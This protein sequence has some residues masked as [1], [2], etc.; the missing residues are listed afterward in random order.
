MLSKEVKPLELES[1]GMFSEDDMNK[2]QEAIESAPILTAEELKK[3]RFHWF[4]EWFEGDIEQVLRQLTSYLRK[5]NRRPEFSH[6]TAKWGWN[7]ETIEVTSW[8]GP[9]SA[10]QKIIWGYTIVRKSEDIYRIEL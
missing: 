9:R 7:E 10:T 1:D 5:H 3:I 6:V 2:L 4:S 8:L